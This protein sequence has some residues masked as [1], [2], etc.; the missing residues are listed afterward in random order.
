MKNEKNKHM[1]LQDRIEIQECL[2]KGMTYKSIAKRIGKSATTVS[3]EVKG[4]LQAHTN[5]FVK[6]DETCPKLLKAPFV[7]NGC[8]KRSR[9]SCQFKRQV[10]I[11]KKAHSDYEELLSEARSGIPL[12]KESFYE[13]EKIISTA[14]KNGQH[15]Y[16]AIK[17]NNLSV[18]MPTVYRH[19]KMGYYSI[20]S[21]D[22]PRAVKF[23]P[24]RSKKSDYVPKCA[25]QGRTY[26][27]Y[28]NYVEENPSLPVVQLDTVIGKIGGK[29]IM[30]IHF[31]DSDF[32]IG[33]LLNP[34][35]KPSKK[36]TQRA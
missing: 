13:T 12:N 15:V 36:P 24:R 1:T 30:T 33:I 34:Q 7:C 2:S 26:N 28:L 10:Y 25:K 17:A 31:T 3:R 19:I 6:T 35:N 32:M 9:S 20:S 29:V 23:K 16:H 27:D 14:V 11:A 18:S 21:I 22:L 5:S 8:E 4:H